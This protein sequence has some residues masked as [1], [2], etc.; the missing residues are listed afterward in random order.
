MKH[1]FLTIYFIVCI[2]GAACAVPL[3]YSVTHY[4]TEDGLSQ[5]TVMY[6]MQ[7][8]KGLMWLATW[9]GLNM[10]NGYEF[11]VYK[12]LA[13]DHVNLSNN[14]IQTI[15]AD[16]YGYIWLL[17]YDYR[18]HRFDPRTEQ[19]EPIYATGYE[20]LNIK[21]ITV[22]PSGSVWL[23]GDHDEAIRVTTDSVSY[24]TT[25]E[26][27]S[28][29]SGMFPSLHCYLVHE[30]YDGNEWLLSDNGI[31]VIP[32]GGTTPERF[33]TA[34][35]KSGGKNLQAFYTIDEDT[36]SVWTGSD[37]G[38]I[39]QYVK[40][41]K[42]FTLHQLPATSRIENI[43]CIG[44]SGLLF[45]TTDS[46]GIFV[47]N[48]TDGSYEHYTAQNTP[49]LAGCDV[50]QV[51]IDSHNEV[52]IDPGR[53]QEVLHY[54]LARRQ[55]KQELVPTKM[56]IA[57]QTNPYFLILEDKR[58]IVWVQPDGS[59][60]CYYDRQ[61]DKLYPLFYDQEEYN[62]TN[63]V[64]SAFSDEL[65]NLWI[66]TYSKGLDKI[67]FHNKPITIKRFDQSNRYSLDSDVR[68]I[69][70]SN[71][72]D[73]FIGLRNGTLQV[74]ASDGTYK[75]VLT[76]NG[77]IS[78]QGKALDAPVYNMVE[79][80][81]GR[82]W[83]A[84]KGNGLFCAIPIAHDRYR[85]EQYRHSDNDIYSLSNDDLYFL[86][87]DK[88]KLLWIATYGGGLNYL[89]L[90]HLGQPVFINHR[91]YLK[92][93]PI[94]ECDR[95]RTIGEDSI[96]NIWVGTTAG[97]LKFD[98]NFGTPD[99]ITFTHYMRNAENRNSLSANDVHYIHTTRRGELY[100][101]TFGGGLNKLRTEG[102]S[103]TIFDV[104]T[105]ADGL[106][107]DVL[108]AIAEDSKGNLW[109]STENGLSKFD[110]QK[111]SFEN[112]ETNEISPQP[113]FN[114]SVVENIGNEIAFGNSS[115]VIMFDP[116]SLRKSDYAP[117]ICLTRLLLANRPVSP[118]KDGVL[119]KVL[120]ETSTLRLE[121]DQNIFTI[122]YA[123]I[124]MRMPQN[125]QYAYMLEGFEKEWN[126]VG[127][128]RSATYTNLPKGTYHFLVR[129]TNSDGIWVDN[130][131]SLTIEILPSFWETPW[132]WALYI[133]AFLLVTGIIVYIF[134]TIY[135]LK[136]EVT[137]EQQV[138][139][140]KLRFFTNISHELRTPL[141]L[142]AGPVEHILTDTSLK[143]DTRNQLLLVKKNTTRMLRLVNQILDFRKIQN[144]KMRMRVSEVNIIP[145]VKQTMQNFNSLAEEHNIQ[146]DL[147]TS[148]HESYLWVDTDKL[149]K[150]LFNLLSNAFKY[151]PQG[152]SITVF[153]EEKDN[154]VAIGVRDEGIGIPA[155]QRDRLFVRFENLLDRNIF[156]QPTTGIGLSLVKELV[157]LHK[158]SIEVESTPNKGS[159]FTV[160]LRKG[161]DH[162]DKD[163]EYILEDLPTPTDISKEEN[164]D[165]IEELS[166]SSS[167]VT[168]KENTTDTILLVE[169]NAELLVF[170]KSIFANQYKV[171]EATDGLEGVEKARKQ[172][173]DIIVSDL[174][175]PR[176][177]GI[178][179]IR[180]LRQEM[181]TSHIPIILLTAKSTTESKIAGL[182]E[183][184]DDYI[185][186]P[187]SAAYLQA[188]VENLLQQRRQ[189]REFYRT[190]LGVQK[191]EETPTAI[192]VVDGVKLTLNDRKFLEKLLELMEKNMGNGDLVV[193]DFV[194]EMAV[195]RSVFF[196]KLKAL[197]GLA[198]IEFIKE[199]RIKRAAQL[200][201]QGDYTMTQIAYMVGIND[202]RYFSKCFKQYYEMTPTEYKESLKKQDS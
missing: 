118:H 106:P 73:V 174:M 66:C 107:S 40:A 148:L 85:I 186:K 52:W 82:L 162:Y 75:G 187:F 192:P 113:R 103:T 165:E 6:I 19:F 146:Y 190:S 18:V 78:P 26:V 30:D 131:R 185:T 76:E 81:E 50:K 164:N 180:E 1:F 179:L 201:K 119:N 13:G 7:D 44:K 136:N 92:K 114:E 182:E 202:P 88:N 64:H 184:A 121:H 194:Q 109:I 56:S 177:D 47:Y 132:A 67:T 48:P 153:I 171:I 16:R 181:S 33:F 139:D 172:Q 200:I 96:G 152:K 70:E 59:G 138:S 143:E 130:E 169:D 90:D 167:G 115:G 23:H 123:A 166:V 189:L 105:H 37:N 86:H 133:I 135:K 9:D 91:N 199:M 87:I 31:G 28:T 89:D 168:D 144:K 173:P 94:N 32:R 74:Y 157:E 38:R 12:A 140:I 176:L 195:S 4:T 5:N 15:E 54:N 149:D 170:L 35:S 2:I 141:T 112:Y 43:D 51:F 61:E 20:A 14:R 68:S 127:S 69:F 129:S 39:W 108:L 27:Y 99:E 25:A 71:N 46:D 161:R 36:Q 158:G 142:I 196:K 101:A 34:S 77:Y 11:T 110:P 188:R 116:D 57:S 17:A 163:V 62:T 80:D 183:G 60:L 147:Q 72:G 55:F 49:L 53:P 84:T 111:K 175:M 41:D 156:N 10:F 193:D 22:L 124:D 45:V 150:I 98:S 151:T 134:T 42:S 29:Q 197:T 95:V 104:Y 145:F 58:G 21:K 79:D 137:I 128:Q 8:K 120:D 93:Y 102:D 178:G 100:L 122:Q 97:A 63:R 191:H 117:L 159:C 198:P 160:Y 3:R 65:G 154:R 83:I 155:N 125:I 24:A 126:Y